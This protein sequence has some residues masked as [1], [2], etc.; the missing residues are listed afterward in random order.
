MKLVNFYGRNV[1]VILTDGSSVKGI[2]N[3]Y[4]D[5]EDNENMKESIIIDTNSGEIIELY[6]H[7]MLSISV[8]E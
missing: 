4:I 7:D 2:V 5:P 1:T 3:D 6:E 8:E